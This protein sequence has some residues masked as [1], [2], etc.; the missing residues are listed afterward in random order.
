M[1]YSNCLFFKQWQSNQLFQNVSEKEKNS[2]NKVEQYICVCL[3]WICGLTFYV[4][5]G[6]AKIN[7]RKGDDII[8]EWNKKQ[9]KSGEAISKLFSDN[10]IGN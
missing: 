1:S 8:I 10:T 6:T 5:L 2:I 7:K 3:E 4:A 9:F